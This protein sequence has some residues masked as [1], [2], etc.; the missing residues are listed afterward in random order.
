MPALPTGITGLFHR[1]SSEE[2]ATMQ[3]DTTEY[4][5]SVPSGSS[6]QAGMK[7]IKPMGDM[8]DPSWDAAN[9]ADVPTQ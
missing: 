9:R 4:V 2:Q 7:V 1:T 3:T 6:S 5:S 8:G